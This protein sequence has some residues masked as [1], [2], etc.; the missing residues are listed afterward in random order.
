MDLDAPEK[1]IEEPEEDPP[2]QP[3]ERTSED[4]NKCPKDKLPSHQAPEERILGCS[5]G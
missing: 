4:V 1:T 2:S 5:T 3:E